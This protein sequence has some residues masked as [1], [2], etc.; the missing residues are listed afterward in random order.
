VVDARFGL[1][2]HVFHNERLTRQHLEAVAAH[3]FDLI[4]IFATR[5]HFDYRSPQAI[6]DLREWLDGLGLEAGSMHAPIFDGFQEGAW[7]RPFSNATP[8]AAARQEAIDETRQALEAARALGC[9]TVVLHLGL[10]RGQTTPPGDNDPA[11]VRRSLDAIGA[12]GR[13]A[14]VRLA[15]ELIPNPLS[16]AD[17]LVQW[18]EDDNGIDDAG[19]CFDTGHGHLMGGA[20]EAA[21]TLSGHIITTHVHDNNGRE[22]AHLVPFTGSIDW[23]LLTMTLGK[24]GYGGPYIFE[25]ADQGNTADTLAR[26]VGARRRLQ[27][28]LADL[29]APFH[30]DA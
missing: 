15:L 23:P 29:A 16:T 5:T 30:F 11:A 7:G 18:I 6:R 26:T 8:V 27:A 19:V 28:I 1:S 2:T 12:A 17:A 25:V 13:E 22:D 10:P 21:E 4:E 20:A 14:G 9:G 3:G 24:I